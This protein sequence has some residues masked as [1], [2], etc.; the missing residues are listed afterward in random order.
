MCDECTW[1]HKTFLLQLVYW[2][3]AIKLYCIVVILIGSSEQGT[4]ASH[5]MPWNSHRSG[6]SVI[7]LWLTFF[8]QQELRQE[9]REGPWQQLQDSAIAMQHSHDWASSS[10]AQQCDSPHL[11]RPWSTRTQMHIHTHTHTHTRTHTHTQMHT[12][13]HT[14]AHTRTHTH[15]HTHTHTKKHMQTWYTYTHI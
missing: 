4:V 15:T 11:P 7:Y 6:Y 1:H 12:N 3:L 9:V 13:A 2:H 14:H 10:L 5:S 8:G